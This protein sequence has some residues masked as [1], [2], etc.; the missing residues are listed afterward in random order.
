MQ[1]QFYTHEQIDKA[2]WDDCIRRSVNALI[3][4]YSFYLDIVCPQWN[5]LVAGDYEVLM[6]LPHRKKFGIKYLYQPAFT[7]QLGIFSPIDTN[8]E[9]TDNFIEE[10]TRRYKFIDL[11][12]NYGN[13][14]TQSN[15]NCNLVLP[16]DRSFVEIKKSFRKDLVNKANSAQLILSEPPANFVIDLF[17]K[18]YGPRIPHINVADYDRLKAVFQALHAREMSFTKAVSNEGGELVSAAIFYK[19]DHR[20][21]YILGTTTEAGRR[22]QANAWLL[23]EVIREYA[24]PHRLFDFEGSN[25]PSIQSFFRKFSAREESYS[26]I[27]INELGMPLSWIKSTYTRWKNA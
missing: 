1:I 25:I 26:S 17:R 27:H 10:A 13:K 9:I 2:K 16:L 12:L 3:Y 6:P 24:G 15:M 20:I 21:Y 22:L 18:E 23:H 4:G 8:Q 19:D 11:N 5:A 14:P 7:Q